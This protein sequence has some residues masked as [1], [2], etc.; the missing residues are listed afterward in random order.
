VMIAL[1]GLCVLPVLWTMRETRGAIA[2]H[3]KRM[4]T[5]PSG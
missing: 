5:T 4:R 1:V 2:V 3:P